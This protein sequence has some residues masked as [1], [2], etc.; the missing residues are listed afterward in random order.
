MTEKIRSDEGLAYMVY[1][2]FNTRGRDYGTTGVVCQTKSKSTIRVIELMKMIINR[3]KTH[4]VSEK[5]LK[6]AKDSLINSFVFQFSDPAKQ[7]L[8]LMML[9]YNEMPRDYYEKYL[10]NIRKVTPDDI[11]AAAQ[12]YLHPDKLTIVVVGKSAD[13]DKSLNS[14]GT[15]PKEI[16]LEEFKE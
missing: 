8:S 2:Y 5:K 4:K 7:V 13:F 9:E 12:K 11:R 6:W 1:S 3:M 10:D 14:L 15:E 16:I